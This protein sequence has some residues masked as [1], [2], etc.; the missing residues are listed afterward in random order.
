MSARADGHDV[1]VSTPARERLVSD[2]LGWAR[3]RPA[4]PPGLASR[5]LGD[6]ERGLAQVRDRLD[7][8]VAR[9]GRP[10]LVSKSMLNRLVCD[11]YQLDFRPFEHSPASVR[12]TLAHAAIALDWDRRRAEPVE[13]V[14]ERVWHEEASREPGR[15][16]SLSAW[17]NARTPDEAVEL[18]AEVGELV[19]AFREVWPLLPEQAVDSRTERTLRVV[20][21]GGRVVL[22]GVPDLVLDSPRD[23]GFARRLVVDLKTGRPRS[24]QDRHELRFYALLDTLLHGKPPF[25]WATYYVTEGRAEWEDLREATLEVT[26]RRVLDGVDQLLRVSTVGEDGL[27]LQAGPWCARCLREADCAVA[28]ARPDTSAGPLEDA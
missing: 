1:D 3:P 15:P 28:A 8:V 11:G 23:D 4:A 7:E 2:L 22:Q 24:E 19:E 26:V 10:L 25:R 27:R 16:G 17:L 5:L 12:G 20:L 9:R 14:V 21:A 13:R 18:R 6:L